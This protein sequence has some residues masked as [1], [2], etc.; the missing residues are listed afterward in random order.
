MRTSVTLFCI[1]LSY[2]LYHHI[3]HIQS[4]MHCFILIH[5]DSYNYYSLETTSEI[6]PFYYIMLGGFSKSFRLNP[7]K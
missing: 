7:P 6:I 3:L 2:I 4:V 1:F 5:G